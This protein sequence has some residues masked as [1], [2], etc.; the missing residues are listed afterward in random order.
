MH[1]FL[2]NSK[3]KRREWEP[4]FR[5]FCADPFRL[6]KLTHRLKSIQEHSG[7]SRSLCLESE[8]LPILSGGKK[9]LHHL[10]SIVIAIELIQLREPEIVA[11]V[12]NV[13]AVIWIAAEVA[14]ELHQ[15]KGAVEFSVE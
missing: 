5:G 15:H 12:V 2:A 4:A 3:M 13:L 11:G 1:A 6:G 8:A 9:C 14:E 7:N 10:G